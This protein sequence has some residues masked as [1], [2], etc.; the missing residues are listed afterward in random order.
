MYV[1]FHIIE[2]WFAAKHIAAGIQN[3]NEAKQ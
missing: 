3:N 2:S 1:H